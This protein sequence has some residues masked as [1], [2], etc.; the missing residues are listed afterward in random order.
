MTSNQRVK[1]FQMLSPGKRET[2]R[3]ERDRCVG[4]KTDGEEEVVGEGDEE[5]GTPM[6]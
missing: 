3:V 5:K 4:W 6:G 2:E 1:R